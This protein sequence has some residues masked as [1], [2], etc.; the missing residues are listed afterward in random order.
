MQHTFSSFIYWMVLFITQIQL[1]FIL[2]TKAWLQ[3]LKDVGF[4]LLFTHVQSIC[5]QYKIDAPH[6]K[7]L[8]VVHVSNK[9]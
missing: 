3:T 6:I 2:I 9:N 7:R 4:D 8:Q 5:T 1:N